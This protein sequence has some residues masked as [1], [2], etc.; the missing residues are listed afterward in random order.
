[1]LMILWRHLSDRR[2]KQFWLLLMLMV[3]ASLAEVVSVG[4]VLP[5]L[6]ILTAPEYVYQHP[7][8]QPLIQFLEITEAGQLALPLTVIFIIAA[9]MAGLIRLALLYMMTRLTFATGA[10]LSIN[11]YRR[12]LYQEYMVHITRNSSEVINGIIGKTGVVI[13]KVISPFLKLI[14]SIVLIIGIMSALFTINIIVALSAFI[15]FG[16][17]YLGV[18]IYTKKRLSENSQIIADQST[19]MIKSLQEGLGGIRD[20]LID[21][22][23]QFYCKLYS[24]ADAPLRR[25]SGDNQFISGSPRYVMEVIGMTLIAILAYIMIQN[26]DSAITAIPVLGALALGA[27]RILPALQQIYGSWSA[28]KSSKAS[29]KDVLDLLEQPLPHHFNQDSITPT[30]FNKEIKLENLSFRYTKN[31]PWILKD[32]NLSISKGSRVGFIGLTGSGKSTILDIIM[33]L[34]PPTKGS[35]TV[36]QKHFN[37]K[38]I[39]EWQ[40]NIAHVPQQI[41]L[42]D[43]TVEENIAFGIPKEKI[44][45]QR[46]KNSAKQ[47]QISDLIEGWEDGYQTFVGERGARLSGGQKQR[48]GIARALYKHANI[49]IFDEATSALDNKTEKSVIDAIDGIHDD[50]TILMVAHRLSTLK[51]CD[52]IVELENGNIKQQGAPTEMIIINEE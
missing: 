48:I 1:M 25:A 42:S 36:D 50:I 32:I 18:A 19:Q 52:I 43:S 26:E 15:G 39:R 12:T 6:G 38:N 23:Q 9:F 13:G 5:F 51:K 3:I 31:T 35:L 21:G 47:A 11:I 46:V 10:D 40:A 17:L 34:L 44:N 4:A 33:G 45:H 22:S 28:I 20:V 30:Q 8:M 27:Q 41:F 37:S 16:L 29:F 24:S 14:S 7:L 2:K 49:L